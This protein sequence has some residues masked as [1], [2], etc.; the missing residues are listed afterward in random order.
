MRLSPALWRNAQVTCIQNYE[1]DALV[2]NA[3]QKNHTLMDAIK[4][5]TSNRLLRSNFIHS[6]LINHTISLYVSAM[7]LI[8]LFHVFEMFIGIN[9]MEKY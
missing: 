1:M 4:K 7:D 3:D 9:S 8:L 2:I 5:F 6:P